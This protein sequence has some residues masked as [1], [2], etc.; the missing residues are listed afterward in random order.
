MAETKSKSKSKAK[1]KAKAKYAFFLGCIAPLRYPGIEKSTRD[2]CN[3]LG[4]ELVDFEDAS[5]CPAPGVI[6]SFDRKTWLAAAARNLALAEKQG[7]NILTIC[8]GCYGSLADA[9]HELNHDEELRKDVNAILAEIGMEYKGGTTVRHFADVLFNDIGMNAIKKAV[10]NPLE[11]KVATFY[12]CHFLKPTDV[13]YLDDPENP[14]MLDDMVEATGASSMFRKDKM[15]CCGAGGG[16]R[17][18]F[19]DFAMKFTEEN[20]KNMKD[21][22]AEAIVDICPFCHLQFDRGQQELKGYDMPVLHLSQLYALAMGMD[23]NDLGLDAHK[24]P[25]K[26]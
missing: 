1:S 17:S 16:L 24:T 7:V 11:L 21:G 15:M 5:C 3:A 26:L 14:R 12:G 23:Q 8:N 19:S 6:K 13:K 2:V 25:V 22:G 20:L 10:T 18:E 4:I 9:A